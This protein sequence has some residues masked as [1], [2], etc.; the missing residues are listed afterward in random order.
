MGKKVMKKKLLESLKN[1]FY[2]IVYE[3]FIY[4]FPIEYKGYMV[5]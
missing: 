3:S 4:V 1:R 5:P 2:K